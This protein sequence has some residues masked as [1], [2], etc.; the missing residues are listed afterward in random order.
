MKKYNKYSKSIGGCQKS[1][2]S[3]T[4]SIVNHGHC[5][6]LQCLLDQLDENTS[7]VE[8]VI[9]T[10]NVAP[11]FP[12]DISTYS[13]QVTIIENLKPLGYGAN[14]NQAFMYCK[15][16]YYCVLNPDIEIL[17][18]PFQKLIFHLSDRSV[19]IAA[20]LVINREGEIEDSY[21]KFPTPFGII[22]KFLFGSSGKYEVQQNV[23]TFKPDWVAGMFMLTRAD[24]YKELTGFDEGYFLYYEDIDICLRAWRLGYATIVSKHASIIHHAQ[25]DSHSKLSYLKIH[26]KS[27]VR[28]FAKHWLRFPR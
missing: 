21:R 4:I 10:H 2:E 19:G 1:D 23:S 28:F 11:S 20:P 3:V 6:M 26:L 14:H 25:R 17:S 5:R 7:A 22:K 9:L 8:H 24:T 12:V 15:T 27:M 13:F 16:K 18:D